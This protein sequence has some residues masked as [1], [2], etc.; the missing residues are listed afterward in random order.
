MIARLMKLINKFYISSDFLLAIAVF[1]LSIFNFVIR[2]LD[3][4]NFPILYAE[5]GVWVGKILINGFWDTALNARSE[6]PV[7]G[8]V[9]LQK[10]S[11]VINALIYSGN[12]FK[13][14]III[15]VVSAAFLSIPV[16]L[17][18]FVSD[19]IIGKKAKIYLIIALL[20]VSVGSDGGEIFGRILNLGFYFPL[21]QLISFLILI[22]RRSIVG[23]V[24]FVIFNVI[25]ILTF[26]V[27]FAIVLL[28]AFVSFVYKTRDSYYRRVLLL[29]VI[30]I[31]ATIYLLASIKITT[32]GAG[33]RLDIENLCEF[34]FARMG[35]Y[36]FIFG[37][38]KYL[39]NAIILLFILCGMLFVKLCKKDFDKFNYPVA[40]IAIGSFAL[41]YLIT[42]IFRYGLTIFLHNYDSSYPDRY[43]YGLNLIFVFMV[44]LVLNKIV[45][46]KFIT[47]LMSILLFNVALKFNSIYE[48]N[49][50]SQQWHSKGDFS[51]MFCAEDQVKIDNVVNVNGVLIYPITE[52]NDWK[53]MIPLPDYQQQ[54]EKYCK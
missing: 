41:Y 26:P 42:L 35:L 5:D 48:F 15:G 38:Y 46:E 50:P 4:F 23:E 52:N 14:P 33:N 45:S 9:L 36:P 34:M 16:A 6:F 31:S 21:Y 44:V 30:S 19:S 22:S 24:F 53:I 17:V 28:M 37:I 32:G 39:N 47:L 8:L 54:I 49:K 27:C 25:S 29:S 11:L 51:K 7:L 3:A 1:V 20:T 13:L 18:V 12:L 2:N 10:I 43:Y 40:A